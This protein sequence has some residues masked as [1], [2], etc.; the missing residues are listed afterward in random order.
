MNIIEG[1]TASA[2]NLRNGNHTLPLPFT[3]RC[4]KF[5]MEFYESG[6]PKTYQSDLTFLRNNQVIYSGKLLVNHPIEVEGFRFYQASYG[7][8]PE[9]KATLAF[10]KNGGRSMDEC[11][12]GIPV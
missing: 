4:D 10:L 8:A 2:I 1:E 5:T 6:A 7:A 11:Q 3:V 12:P 9:G